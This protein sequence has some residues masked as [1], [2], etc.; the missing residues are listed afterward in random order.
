MDKV[1]LPY[2]RAMLS[3]DITTS[4]ANMNVGTELEY[5]ISE[6]WVSRTSYQFNQSGDKES[7][8]LCAYLP[9]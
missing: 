2:D 6:N 3:D 4:R 7:N 9:Q 5:R 8:F 1:P